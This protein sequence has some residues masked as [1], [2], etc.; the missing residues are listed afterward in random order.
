MAPHL[1]AD[2]LAIIGMGNVALD[3]ARLLCL[4]GKQL[5]QTDIADHALTALANSIPF[6]A[7]LASEPERRLYLSMVYSLL[8]L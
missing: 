1:D 7:D 5:Q 6:D 8:I 2:S 3:I 4:P